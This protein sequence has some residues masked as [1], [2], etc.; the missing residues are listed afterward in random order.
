MNFN[1]VDN[2]VKK[3][4]QKVFNLKAEK[5]IRK[6]SDSFLYLK[7]YDKALALVK[8][9]LSIDSEHTKAH[10]LK[11]DILLCLD[12]YEEALSSYENAVY[13]NPTS[14]QAYGSKA[15]VLDMMNRQEEALESCEKA[16][17]C[18]NYTDK[19]L[20]LSLYDQK[21]SLLTALK[22]YRKAHQVL[23]EAIMNLPGED[24]SYL[25]SC[26]G[27]F[28]EDNDQKNVGNLVLQLL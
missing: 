27:Q 19:Q 18:L 15:G 8:E 11:G 1:N 4:N 22:H 20:L 14:A 13:S 21:I 25:M 12:N 24:S 10:L 17:E 26:Y 3:A 23:S 6:A 7:N 9:V 2:S 28:I 16:F 5:L